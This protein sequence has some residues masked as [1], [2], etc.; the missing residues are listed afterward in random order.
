MTQTKKRTSSF[1]FFFALITTITAQQG[2]VA[3]GGDASGSGGSASYSTGQVD[4]ITATGATGT[5]TQGLQQ[6]FEI[7]VITGNDHAH[8]NLSAVVYPNPATDQVLIDVAGA[9]AANMTYTLCDVHGKI[10]RSERL[11]GSQT[12]IPMAELQKAIYLIKV[13]NNNEE[14][15]IF[16]II[17][18]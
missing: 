1:C 13:L 14:V 11:N 3:T 18:N 9:S 7:S 2:T 5:I 17:K 10:I 16:K 4:H 12:I 6:P 8:I 15:K